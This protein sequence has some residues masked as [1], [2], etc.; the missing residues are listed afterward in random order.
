MDRQKTGLTVPP[1]SNFLPKGDKEYRYS[2]ELSFQIKASTA[3]FIIEHSDQAEDPGARVLAGIDGM[4]KAYKVILE[5]NH[6]SDFEYL[7]SLL[8]A[9]E[10]NQLQTRVQ[11]VMSRCSDVPLSDKN[12]R[13]AVGEILYASI[14]VD[15][16]ALV[17]DMPF[18]QYPPGAKRNFTQGNV[19]LHVVL[20]SNGNVTDVEVIKGLPDGL[21]ESSMNAAKAITFEP[22]LMHGQRVSTVVR[23][24]Y[25]FVAESPL[26]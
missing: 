2:Q 11:E 19:V 17:T 15:K 20:S 23:F 22:A 12:S 18:P 8:K 24:E 13:H 10:Y 9:Q 21:T 25:R 14:E 6:K 4:L 1:C 3:A 16:P 7:N 26:R 5:K